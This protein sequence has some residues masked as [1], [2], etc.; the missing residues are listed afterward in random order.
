LGDLELARDCVRHARMFFDRPDFDLAS[1]QPGTFAI[2]PVEGMID[3]LRRDYAN[4][5][6]MIFGEPPSFDLI[7][8]SMQQLHA[9][10]NASS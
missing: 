3:A 10:A 4:T 1:A 9:A 6:A 5:A 7:L 2:A 8:D